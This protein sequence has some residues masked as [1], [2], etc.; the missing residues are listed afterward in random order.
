MSRNTVLI[1]YL[2]LLVSRMTQQKVEAM[3]PEMWG[4]LEPM[5]NCKSLD[6]KQTKQP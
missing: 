2:A 5:K 6:C 3:E 4:H 1:T